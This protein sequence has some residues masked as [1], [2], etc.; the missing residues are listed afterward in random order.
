MRGVQT[1]RHATAGCVGGK[2]LR[3]KGEVTPAGWETLE[4]SAKK[5]KNSTKE[6][7]R[8]V[9]PSRWGLP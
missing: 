8:G 4:M 3:E 1:G 6:I 2:P 7:H 9:V 5:K